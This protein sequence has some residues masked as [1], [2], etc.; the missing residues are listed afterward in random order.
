MSVQMETE[1]GIGKMMT[2]T[3]YEGGIVGY[4]VSFVSEHR[5]IR[6]A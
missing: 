3:R 6:Q 4:L 2:E 1:A 5:S